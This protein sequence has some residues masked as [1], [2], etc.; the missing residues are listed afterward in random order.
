MLKL[1]QGITHYCMEIYCVLNRALLNSIEP[2]AVGALSR[3]LYKILSLN[4][5]DIYS[6]CGT[7]IRDAWHIFSLMPCAR[8]PPSYRRMTLNK[9]IVERWR[10]QLGY[11]FCLLITLRGGTILEYSSCRF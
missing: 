11:H 9:Q 7:G 1:K 10:Q 8:L 4:S 5:G 2:R 3:A 6:T